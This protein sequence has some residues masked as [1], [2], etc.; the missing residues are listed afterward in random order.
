MARYKKGQ[1]GNP[2]GRPKGTKDSRTALRELLKPHA[3]ALV[4]KAVDQA[5]EGDA[6]AL[7]LC[8]DRLIPAMPAQ[9]EPV[10][11]D[12]SPDDLAQAGREVLSQTFAGSISVTVAGQLLQS[13]Q[14]QARITEIDELVRRIEALEEQRKHENA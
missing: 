2:S 11:I 1:S 6:Q 8:L 10:M 3:P 13:L 7:R 9:A 12:A 5:L 14:G 4:K